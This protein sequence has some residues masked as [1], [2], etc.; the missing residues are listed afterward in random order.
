[1]FCRYLTPFKKL[2]YDVTFACQ[3]EL[4][5]FFNLIPELDNIKIMSQIPQQPFDKRTFLMS[6][7]WLMSDLISKKIGKPL[8]IDNERFSKVKLIFLIKLKKLLKLNN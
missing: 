3:P 7:P 2:G 5:E 8:K 6:L 4:I 1:M